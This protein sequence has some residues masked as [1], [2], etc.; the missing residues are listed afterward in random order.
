MGWMK[1]SRGK[2]RCERS[3]AKSHKVPSLNS[4]EELIQMWSQKQVKLN[5]DSISLII[6]WWKHNRLA[7]LFTVLGSVQSGVKFRKLK[8]KNKTLDLEKSNESMTCGLHTSHASSS[9]L[10]HV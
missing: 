2:R 5:L 8:F 1:W 6:A 4:K 9:H 10:A 3:K 7:H